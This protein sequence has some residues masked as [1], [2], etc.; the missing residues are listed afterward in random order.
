[1]TVIG[2]TFPTRKILAA[3]ILS[4]MLCDSYV[5]VHVP[6]SSDSSQHIFLRTR[7][8]KAPWN[9]GTEMATVVIVR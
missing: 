5:N 4:A 3:E 2:F 1:M 7:D 6:D 8:A 9:S